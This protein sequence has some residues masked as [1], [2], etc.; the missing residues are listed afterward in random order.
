MANEMMEMERYERRPLPTARDLVAV[1]FRQRRLI[2]ACFVGVVVLVFLSGM[3]TRKY[4]AHMK[5]LVLRQRMDAAVTAQPNA[6]PEVTPEVTEEDL[7]SEVELL[8]SD[9]LLRNVVLATGLQHQSWSLFGHVNQDTAIA[10]AVHALDETLNVEP[11]PKA[12]VIDVSY[13]SS[14]PQL[15][16]KVLDAVESAYLEKHQEVHRPSGEFQFFSQ[17]T[18]H[19][20][21]G[22]EQSQAKLAAF[23]QTNGVVAAQ[24]ERDLTLQRVA[25]FDANAH[26]AQAEAADAAQRIHSLQAQLSAM[27]PRLTTEVRTG[28][29][30]QLM[31]QLKSTLLNLELK[32]TELL[33]KFDPSYRLVQET[34][35]QIAEASAAIASENGKP[36][37]EKTTDQDPTYEMLRSE[38]AKAKEELVGLNARATAS[39]A[40]AN[41]YRVTARNLEQEGLQQEDLERNEK[42]QEDN[43]LLYLNKREEARI[44]DALDQRGI[45]NVAVAE[46]PMAPAIPIQS[47]VKTAGITLLLG[48]FV[49]MGAAFVTDYADPSFR[50]PAEVAGYLDMPVLASLPRSDSQE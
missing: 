24:E 4:E 32:R 29:N 1:I 48:F 50:T 43:Y 47:P 36:P 33:T 3:W 30:L 22:L 46:P 45:L 26:E 28:E 38:L 10:I 21:Q 34:D 40:I 11:V 5:I 14:D 37:Q 17:Q 31:Q 8:R 16:A 41:E 27:Q 44:S 20:H 35:K 7:N 12:N 13:R 19:F 25:D 2:V 42:T 6:P 39:V 15:A 23:T 49:S 18:E 9:D